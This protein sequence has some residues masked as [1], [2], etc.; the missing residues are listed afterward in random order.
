MFFKSQTLEADRFASPRIKL[1]PRMQ[2]IS[3]ESHYQHAIR[4]WKESFIVVWCVFLAFADKGR[5][6]FLKICKI[7][8]NV[9][10]GG[11]LKLNCRKLLTVSKVIV[12]FLHSAL[13]KTLFVYVFLDKRFYILLFQ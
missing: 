5:E 1:D 7:W 12:V 10:H 13:P 4:N 3:F 8:I 2:S 9:I 6:S 11:P